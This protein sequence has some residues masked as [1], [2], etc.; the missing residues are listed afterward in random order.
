MLKKKVL[1]VALSLAVFVG[2]VNAQEKYSKVKV[3]L[4]SIEAKKELVQLLQ[5]DHFQVEDNALICEIGEAELNALKGN[6]FQ[7]EV[8]IS[9]LASYLIA[10]NK[11]AD[12]NRTKR[13]PA[14]GRMAYEAPGKTVTGMIKKPT[15][16]TTA[17]AMGGY[18]SYAEME[19]AMNSLVAAYPGL[20]SKYTI[21][22]TLGNREIWGV[23][24]S[25]NVGTDE[26][27]PEVLYTGLQHA[28]EAITGTS[29][30]FLMQYLTENYSSDSRIQELVNSREIFIIPCVNVDGYEYNRTSSPSGGGMW[31]KNRNGSGVD[32][33]RNYSVDWGKSGGGSPVASDETY[34]G[35]AAFSELETQAIRN[36]VTSRNFT[37]A[38]DQHCYG[39]YYSLPYGMPTL[40]S[41]LSAADQNFYSYV[42]AL[43]GKHNCH[44]AG[45]SPQTV[46]YEVAGG[47]KD[48]FLMGDVGMGTKGK[49]MGM[50]G[51]AGGGGFWATKADIIPLCQGLTFQN[52]QLAYSAGSYVEHQDLSEVSID[53]T[54]KTGSFSYSVRRVGVG[55]EPVTVSIVPIENIQ[56][57]GAPVTVAS[58]PNYF[59]VATGSI[60]YTLPASI[61][62]AQRVRFAW[63]VET[64]GVTILD[65]VSKVFA[66]V[67]LMQDDME[68]GTS[69]WSIVTKGG[70]PNASP[71]GF[72][73]DAAYAGSNSLTDSPDGD[74]SAGKQFS[75][76]FTGT[77]DLSNATSAYLSF[78]TKYRAENCSD[79]LQIQVSGDNG[80]TYSAVAGRNTI[81]ESDGTLGGQ[82][83]LTGIRETWTRELID[84]SSFI[85]KNQVKL[86]FAFSSN[87]LVS[88]DDFYKQ[89]DDGFYIDNV[90]MVKST[91]TL[92]PLP[93]TFVNFQ[94]KLLEDNSV[95]LWWEA[96]ADAEHDYFEIERS[97]DGTN[98]TSL[99]KS[100]KFPPYQFMDNHPA[101]GNNLYRLKQVDKDG[102]FTYSKTININIDYQVKALL[103][104]NPVLD[105]LT[106]KLKAGHA[107]NVSL[108]ITDLLGKQ[109]FSTNKAGLGSSEIKVDVRSWK[110][111]FYILMLYNSKDEI[112]ST[113]KFVKQ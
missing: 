37:V 27:E 80:S 64:G 84:L 67:V 7:Y 81:S 59:D 19:T 38:I 50:T 25:D 89:V 45:N 3:Y 15:A 4:P 12:Q 109:V 1:A 36:F 53:A 57:V 43:M 113:Q 18:Y 58:L 55:N 33:N 20:V 98:F 8:L 101:V 41:A 85:G 48:W 91:A 71:W 51:E 70:G 65:T 44:R 56:S 14:N 75:I 88:G 5:L 47:I 69:K 61:S 105:I 23:K 22:K 107:E 17:G 54:A 74:Y 100:N 77:L 79:K 16:F 106:V 34:W 83:A 28:R 9:D 21:G 32:I 78:W 11:R 40:H 96:F 95:Q 111:Q 52:L 39:E 26:S 104:P 72:T 87:S 94:G 97:Q 10:Q 92:T 62:S 108:R 13:T 82:P 103:Y 76:D 49:V 46:G 60:S 110:P 73:T 63:K 29:L 42:P 2:A 35:T 30:I 90:M 68:S 66:P 24:I 99:G 112:V 93:V 6:R 31:R 102:K 86:R